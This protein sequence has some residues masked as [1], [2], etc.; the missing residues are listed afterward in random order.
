M[1]T[2]NLNLDDQFC[3][4]VLNYRKI[5]GSL[6]ILCEGNRDY[7]NIHTPQQISQLEQVEDAN[8]WR[9]TIPK[10]W[11][12]K[13]PVFIPCGGRSDVLRIKFRLIELHNED[14][15]NSYL[16]P[17]KLYALIDLDIQSAN[18]NNFSDHQYST[19][20]DLYHGIY[21]KDV[22]NT[23]PIQES[24][25]IIT[26]WIH[27]EAYFLE[28]DL[29][30]YLMNKGFELSY[31]SDLLTFDTIYQEMIN[32]MVTDQDI[33]KNLAIVIKRIQSKLTLDKDDI[34]TLK[35]QLKNAYHNPH[36]TPEI[37][38]SLINIMLKIIKAKPFWKKIEVNDPYLQ[39]SQAKDN[40]IL[41][42]ADFYAESCPMIEETMTKSYHIPQWVRYLNKA[43]S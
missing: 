40:L 9:K 14:P 38:R 16:S 41:A 12:N 15:E 29:E 11:R 18:L 30:S 28:P 17:D 37:R 24:K 25:T 42:I 21:E 19:T 23:D 4:K 36:L 10:W 2:A 13:Q 34:I 1:A 27:K 39:P 35:D 33:Q 5:K 31:Q 32:N 43:I 8:F 26:G 3:A 6:V 20:E 7:L 22:I